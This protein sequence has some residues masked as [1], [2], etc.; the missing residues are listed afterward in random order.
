MKINIITYIIYLTLLSSILS[1]KKVVGLLASPNP[2]DTDDSQHSYFDSNYIRWL[3]QS[4]ARVY[5]IQPW[6]TEAQVLEILPQINGVILL[7]GSR[8]LHLDGQYERIVQIIINK[9]I[10]YKDKMNIHL[11]LWGTCQGFELLHVIFAKTHSVLSDFNSEEIKLPLKFDPS[12]IK[13]TRM[14]KEFSDQNLSDLANKDVTAH[15]HYLGVKPEDYKTYP[16][17]NE[18]FLATSTGFDRDGKEFIAT[19][20][21]RRYP[22]YATQFHPEDVAFTEVYSE[23]IPESIEAV[24]I[25]QQFI[26]FFLSELNM[27]DNK[28]DETKF[29]LFNIWEEKAHIVNNRYFFLYDKPANIFL[30]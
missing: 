24:R 28:I 17:L 14:F 15:F 8:F 25:S 27:N 11:P 12:T 19:I 4:G 10:E 26:N 21:G 6:F 29:P 13:S 22:F 1:Y 5:I 7:G 23:G 30:G 9:I 18:L 3:E 16:I 20:E 2:S